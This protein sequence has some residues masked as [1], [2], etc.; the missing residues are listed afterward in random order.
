MGQGKAAVLLCMSLA[1]ACVCANRWSCCYFTP[2]FSVG[3][4]DVGLIFWYENDCDKKIPIK[5]IQHTGL[6]WQWHSKH[7]FHPTYGNFT[8]NAIRGSITLQKS[9]VTASHPSWSYLI[10]GYCF[11]IMNMFTVVYLQ[12]WWGAVSCV[13]CALPGYKSTVKKLCSEEIIYLILF[14]MWSRLDTKTWGRN[15]KRNH[16]NE[17]LESF[18]ILFSSMFLTNNLFD[19]NFLA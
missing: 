2:S 18:S 8:C 9:I 7:F 17:Y 1:F 14:G 10:Q 4:H 15:H 19:C 3:A 11:A 12:R 6:D 13:S 16:T 5:H